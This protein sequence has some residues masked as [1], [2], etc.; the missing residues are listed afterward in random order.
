MYSTGLPADVTRAAL[1]ALLVAWIGSEIWIRSSR[2][3]HSGV[4]KTTRTWIGVAWLIGV[5][6][7]VALANRGVGPVIAHHSVALFAVGISLAVLGIALRLWAVHTLGRFFQLVLV[8]Q[9]E[10]HVVSNGPYRVI[11]HPSYAGPVLAFIGVGLALNHWVS[12]AACVVPPTAAVVHRILVEEKMLVDGL[13]SEYQ[14]YR[15][16]TRRLVP[17]VW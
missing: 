13:G 3:S 11:R 14:Q 4:P 6:G 1:D 12:L 8:V 15:R 10:H 5:V 17:F 7:G 2:P 16:R 9:S